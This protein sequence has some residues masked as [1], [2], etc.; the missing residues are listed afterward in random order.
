MLRRLLWIS[1]ISATCGASSSWSLQSSGNSFTPLCCRGR[2]AVRWEQ[3]LNPKPKIQN[4]RPKLNKLLLLYTKVYFGQHLAQDFIYRVSGLRVQGSGFWPGS[5]YTRRYKKLSSRINRS[6][7][8]PPQTVK[9]SNP[10]PESLN[11]WEVPK[12]A[13]QT[14]TQ[15]PHPRQHRPS[16]ETKDARGRTCCA[17]Y[18]TSEF[19][20]LFFLL[21][22]AVIEKQA[23]QRKQ[24]SASLGCRR[25]LP[26]VEP[27]R[28][29]QVASRL[30]GLSRVEV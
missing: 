20:L 12:L 6:K 14:G 18:T 30:P 23:A 17:G 15:I 1:S 7:P 13:T 27:R 26:A 16:T 10:E 11:K 8:L 21:A 2:Y 3:T 22:E 5:V 19:G 29:P 24:P 9:L 25:P 4:P 28:G